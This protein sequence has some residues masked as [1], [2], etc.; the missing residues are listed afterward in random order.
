MAAF[1]P[2]KRVVIVQTLHILGPD[3]NPRDFDWQNGGY[4]SFEAYEGFN[5]W[6]GRLPRQDH[7]KNWPSDGIQSDLS[8]FDELTKLLRPVPFEKL[9][10]EFPAGE[11]T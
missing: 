7:R 2:K 3:Q 11:L 9:Y 6:C 8:K 10:P 4:L 5:A 1:D